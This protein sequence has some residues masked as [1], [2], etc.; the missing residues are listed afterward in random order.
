M[1]PV[2]LSQ[3]NMLFQQLYTELIRT[4]MFYVR[5]KIAVEDIVQEVYVK[6]WER[7]EET[8]SI[9]NIK[10]YLQ[11]AVRNQCL[12]YLKYLR[13]K[14]E[15]EQK[16]QCLIWEKNNSNEEYVQFVHR[17]LHNLPPKRRMI[18]ELSMLESKTYQEIAVQENIS[19]NT[20][21]DHI[22]KAYTFLRKTA[23]TSPTYPKRLY[24]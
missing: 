2:H 3:F 12:N 22:K 23:V 19:I 14:G 4:G 17:L 21:K 1:D 20:V 18:F 24:E 5:D 9:A 8:K 10:G 6:L 15:Y 16:Y 13:I 7:F 11:Y